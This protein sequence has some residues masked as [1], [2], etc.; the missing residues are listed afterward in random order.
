MNMKKILLFGAT[1]MAGHVVYTYLQSLKKYEIQNVVYRQ[2][3]NPN[4]IVVDVTN[5]EA[6]SSVNQQ[7]QP[8]F[9]INCIGVLIKGSQN[10]PDN[11]I[12]ILSLIHI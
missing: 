2:K 7:Y 10:H 11:A 5:K 8:D 12:Y 1:G 4:S 9:I 6:V 3:L